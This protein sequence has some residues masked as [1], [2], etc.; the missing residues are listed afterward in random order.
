MC[1]W[2]ATLD[3]EFYRGNDHLR[4]LA[5]TVAFALF[6]IIQDD[7]TPRLAYA[8]RFS[9]ERLAPTYMGF[10]QPSKRGGHCKRETIDRID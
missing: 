7:I 9:F 2:Y 1:D 5:P 8:Q 10:E 6:C 3:C 4:D